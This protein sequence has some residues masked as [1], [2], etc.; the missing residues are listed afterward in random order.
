MESIGPYRLDSEIGH[1]AMGV[2]FRR[3]DPAIG[4]NVVSGADGFAAR[5]SNSR[6]LPTL[7]TR[8]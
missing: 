4:R 7:I 6:A 5:C 1:G 3:F 8:R 2:V